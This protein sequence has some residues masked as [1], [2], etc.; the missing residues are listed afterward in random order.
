MDTKDRPR[1]ECPMGPQPCGNPACAV[2]CN[3]LD[4]PADKPAPLRVR[5][6]VQTSPHT[7]GIRFTR[8]LTSEEC[9]AIPRALLRVLNEQFEEDFSR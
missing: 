9:E 1:P 8:A 3:L 4:D 2:R 5:E 6:W 7:I